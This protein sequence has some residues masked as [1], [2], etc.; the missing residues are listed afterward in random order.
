MF[1]N[2]KNDNVVEQTFENEKD[3]VSE[4]SVVDTPA[5]STDNL[6]QNRDY[7][8]P[9]L[10]KDVKTISIEEINNEKI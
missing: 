6:E 1:E 7:L 9:S 10:F 3:S 5:T 8:D 4:I 2:I